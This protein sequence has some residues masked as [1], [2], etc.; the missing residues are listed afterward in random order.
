MPAAA[1]PGQYAPGVHGTGTSVPSVGQNSEAGQLVQSAGEPPPDALRKVPGT[2]GTG[3]TALAPHQCPNGQSSPANAVVPACRHKKPA[4]HGA[5][6]A[7]LLPPVAGLYV[8][9]SHSVSSPPTQNA[10]MRH[11]LGTEVPAS[12]VNPSG[13]RRQSSS[14]VPPETLRSVRAGHGAGA[15]APATQNEPGGHTPP[16]LPAAS[17]SAEGLGTLCARRH[18]WPA[19]HAPTTAPRWQ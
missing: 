19:S 6:D 3:A 10:P 18:Q 11:G 16:P 12:H 7:R 5:H 9:G 14:R 13:H 4:G 15:V 8:P 17:S 2:H 1:P